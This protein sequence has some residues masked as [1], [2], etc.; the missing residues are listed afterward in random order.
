MADGGLLILIQGIASRVAS[1]VNDWVFGMKQTGMNDAAIK[2]RL[3]QE[4]E[5]GRIIT[6]MKNF[7]QAFVPG[8]AGDLVRRFG[9]DTVAQRIKDMR[10][11]DF[12]RIR[13]EDTPESRRRIE[14]LEKKILIDAYNEGELLPVPPESD[15]GQ[16]YI[17]ISVRG[18]NTCWPCWNRHGEEKTMEGWINAGVPRSN[19][20][21]GGWRCRCE[22]VPMEALDP[23]DIPDEIVVPPPPPREKFVWV[24]LE[25]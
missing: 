14:E 20:C 19:F 22:L 3:A 21:L 11:R 16:K 8:Y 13:L 2:T 9:R 12:E 18:K 7:A 24:V 17:W 6:E 4:I 15:M 1:A 10:T 25:A 5:A 23:D